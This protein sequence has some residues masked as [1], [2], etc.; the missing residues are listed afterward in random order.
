MWRGTALIDKLIEGLSEYLETH[1]YASIAEL[2]GKAQPNL[3]K[4][5]ELSFTNKLKAYINVNRCNGCA[6]CIKA[7]DGGGYQAIEL[8]DSKGEIVTA[9]CDGCGLCVGICPT[10]AIKMVTPS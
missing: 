2:R 9:R 7:C 1:H 10:A 5:D 4:Y 8:R 3:I 6:L